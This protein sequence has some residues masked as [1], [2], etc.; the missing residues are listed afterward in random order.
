MQQ[1]KIEVLTIVVFVAASQGASGLAD[2]GDR[3][4][5]SWGRGWGRGSHDGRLGKLLLGWLLCRSICR[6]LLARLHNQVSNIKLS[7]LDGIHQAVQVAIAG[8]GPS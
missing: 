3:L 2:N 4:G 7:P 6:R 8:L 5:S 1:S